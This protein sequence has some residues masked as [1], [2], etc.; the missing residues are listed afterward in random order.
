MLYNRLLVDMSALTGGY[1]S[2]QPLESQESGAM[3]Y[4]YNERNGKIVSNITHHL[5]G[6][7]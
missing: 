4:V 7:P 5:Q 2:R 3:L 6:T 1:E